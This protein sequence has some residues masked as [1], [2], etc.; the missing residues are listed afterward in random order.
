M[1]QGR[2]SIGRR[3]SPLNGWGV[4]AQT[5]LKLRAAGMTKAANRSKGFTLL[6][7]LLVL[8][9]IGLII[10]VAGLSVGSGSRRI[11]IDAAARHFADLAAYALEE[12]EFNGADLGL[13]FTHGGEGRY[14]YQWLRRASDPRDSI[15]FPP[16]NGASEGNPTNPPPAAP[17]LGWQPAQLLDDAPGPQS[18]PK[19]IELLLEVEQIGTPLPIASEARDAHPRPQVIFSSSGE[20]TPAALTWLDAATGEILWE[21]EWD[22][23]GRIRTRRPGEE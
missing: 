22:L 3:R 19:G 18:L 15:L 13:L 5:L 1:K 4:I 12:A 23:F 11:E 8:A 14:R 2:L 7:I 17:A 9:V 21:T 20:V 6:E 10:T 16:R